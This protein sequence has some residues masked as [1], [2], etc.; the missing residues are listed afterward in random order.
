MNIVLTGLRGTGKSRIGEALAS[1]LGFAFIDIDKEI[2]KK[3]GMKIADFVGS[4]G[5]ERFREVEQGEAL[6]VSNLDKTVIAT[7]GG[8]ILDSESARALKKNGVFVFLKASLDVLAKRIAADAS[9][10]GR[11]SLTGHAP[12]EELNDIWNERKEIY[13]KTADIVFDVSDETDDLEKD[14]GNKAQKILELLKSYN[15]VVK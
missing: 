12:E 1:R 3:V 9:D 2:E 15:I 6:R 13:E 7:G 4:E 11:P 5:W 10:G 14:T 8:T